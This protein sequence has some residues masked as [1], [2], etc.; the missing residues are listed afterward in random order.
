MRCKKLNPDVLRSYFGANSPSTKAY[1]TQ[2]GEDEFFHE[3][4]KFLPE[5]SFLS[6]CFYC[7]PKKTNGFIIS[8]YEGEVFDWGLLTTEALREQLDGVQNGKPM[9]PIFARWLV[10]LYPTPSRRINK[11]HRDRHKDNRHHVLESQ[12]HERNG[13]NQSRH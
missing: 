7:M 9:K 10:V 13:T 6:P 5:V 2:G 8:T 11:T 1:Q 3:V 12:C 4:V